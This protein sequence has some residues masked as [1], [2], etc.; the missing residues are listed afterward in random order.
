VAGAVVTLLTGDQ[1]A[2]GGPRGA[3]ARPAPGRE[4]ISFT[5]WTDERGHVHVLPS[6]VSA[7]VASGQFDPLLFDVTA[8][9]EAGYDNASRPDLP[10]IVDY[11]AATP[12]MADTTVVD[13]LPILSAVAVRAE[14]GGGFWA[15]GQNATRIWLDAPVQAS[16]DRSV[17]QVG[18]PAAWAAGYTGAGT[19]VAVLDTGID[20]SHPDLA[21]AVVGEQDF[22]GGTTGT[23]DVAGH[24]THVASTIT[25]AGRYSGVAPD[26]VLLNGKVLDDSGFGA[27]SWIISGMEWAAANGADVVN[28]SLGNSL[29][30]DGSDPLSQAVNKL[31]EQTGTLFVVAAGNDGT[32]GLT[33]GSPAAAEQALTVGAV[34]RDDALADFS[35]P[36]PRKGD[37][38]IKPDVTAPGVGIVAA[39][40]KN[41]WLGQPVEGDAARRGCRGDPRREH[42]DWTPEQIKVAL[43]NTAVPSDGATVFQQGAGRIDVAAATRAQVRTVREPSRVEPQY[44]RPGPRPAGHSL[45]QRRGPHGTAARRR[46]HRRLPVPV[47]REFRGGPGG[48]D[49]HGPLV[50]RPFGPFPTVHTGQQRVDVPDEERAGLPAG[51]TAPAGRALRSEAGC[52]QRR[53]GRQDVP[54]P[55]L[56]PAWW[57]QH[58][59]RTVRRTDGGGLLRRRHDVAAGQADPRPRPVAGGGAPPEGRDVRV[60]A[61][62][63]R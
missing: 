59:D 43:M 13:E 33:V 27:T 12:R 24:G 42:P 50:R 29:P 57:L 17:P 53:A 16:L 38:G 21:G 31:T 49:V 14:H 41:G 20:T 34:D 11:P 44:R 62:K 55:G 63:R 56:R 5:T 7:K 37:S 2:L 54:L 26:A 4:D 15:S 58:A 30:S 60:T 18:A 3:Q 45:V 6:D 48:D 46:G 25:G 32:R 52:A 1:V 36:G 22:T 61:G 9:V 35:T 19:K 23:D 40:A 51:A 28:L 39:K 8:L 47:R 10:L